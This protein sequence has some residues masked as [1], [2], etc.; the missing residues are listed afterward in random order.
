MNSAAIDHSLIVR[1]TGIRPE[2]PN[3]LSRRFRSPA[4]LATTLGMRLAR[5]FVWLRQF[6]N[7]SNHCRPKRLKPEQQTQSVRLQCV[8]TKKIYRSATTR[9]TESYRRR[10]A[11]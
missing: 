2:V 10:L 5:Y 7:H 9:L 11:R 3:N 8:R 4:V 6:R 1:S